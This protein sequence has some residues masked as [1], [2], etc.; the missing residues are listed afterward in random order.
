[1]DPEEPEFCFSGFVL[2]I[3]VTVSPIAERG[4][5]LCRATSMILSTNAEMYFNLAKISLCSG[6]IRVSSQR[7][8]GGIAKRA[9]GRPVIGAVFSLPAA[10]KPAKV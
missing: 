4:A 3:A 8:G 9:A 1:M 5:A 10:A 2:R 6:A 7:A